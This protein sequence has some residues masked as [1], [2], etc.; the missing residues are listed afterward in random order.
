MQRTFALTVVASLA[1][2]GLSGCAAPIASASSGSD[3]S[4]GTPWGSPS[5]TASFGAAP[6]GA[7][8]VCSLLPVAKVAA[9]TGKPFTVAKNFDN[10]GYACTYN[11]EGSKSWFWEVY[12]NNIGQ[13]APTGPDILIGADGVVKPLNG[14][15]YPAISAPDGVALQWDTDDVVVSDNST[16]ASSRGTTSQYVAVAEALMATINQSPGN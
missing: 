8:D 1:V 3:G 12:I 2:L 10:P 6:T 7:V 14:I 4:D 16:Y 11:V 15:A 5:G 9:L 13:K